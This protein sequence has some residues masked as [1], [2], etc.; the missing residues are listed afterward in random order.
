MSADERPARLDVIGLG[1]AIVDVIAPADE[2]LLERLEL[3]KGTMTL[4]EQERMAALYAQMGPAVEM[5]GGSCANT[6]GRARRARRRGGLCR[7]GAERPAG[8]GVRPRHPRDRGR[9]PR[10][11]RSRPARRPRAA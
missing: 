6:H 2:R 10:R 9:V 8:R 1:N 3:A 11:R 4:I 5:S 7:Q